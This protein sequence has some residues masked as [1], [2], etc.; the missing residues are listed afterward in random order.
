MP[1]EYV[2]REKDLHLHQQAYQTPLR[3]HREDHRHSGT[4]LPWW[5]SNLV[6]YLI[7]PFLISIASAADLSFQAL[8]LKLYTISAPFYRA[9]GLEYSSIQG[10]GLDLSISK[11]IVERHGGQI[12]VESSE[13]KGTTFFVQLPLQIVN[14]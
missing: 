10:W 4:H 8:G 5:R 13:G 12:W 6:G 11:E 1:R 3:Q 2:K 7:C 14:P 9:P